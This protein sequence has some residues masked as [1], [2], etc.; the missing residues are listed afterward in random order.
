MYISIPISDKLEYM[1]STLAFHERNNINGKYDGVI[2][3]NKNSIRVLIIQKIHNIILNI[4]KYDTGR[5]N[6]N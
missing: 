3:A 5:T 1:R 6:Y 4:D 2:I